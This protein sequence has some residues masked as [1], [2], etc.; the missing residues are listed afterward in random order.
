MI[1][2]AHHH[3]WR[4][5]PGQTPWLD[6][7]N[8]LGPLR[9][10]YLGGELAEHLRANGIARSVIVQSVDATRDT[11]FMRAAAREHDFIAGIVA[12]VP[13]EDPAATAKQLGRYAR[14]PAIKGFRHLILFEP[15]PDWS[16]RPNVLTSLR[17]V[18]DAGYTWDASVAT[19]RHLEH[20]ATIAE[21][22]PHLAQVID[23][24]GK[25]PA[26]ESVWEPWASLMAR[27]ATYP[28]VC[29]KLSGLLNVAT[30]AN[31][32]PH[33]L[34]PYVDHVLHCFGARRTMIAS[35]WPVSELGAGYTATW[36][37]TLGMLAGL[38]AHDREQVLGASAARFYRLS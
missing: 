13:L 34:Q 12:W 21:R 22:I 25:P 3:L 30:L 27:A 10:D 19:P 17:L 4:Y 11:E 28:N 16:I 15:D 8:E 6:A 9:R 1:V 29:V 20:V 38:E 31:P 23:H 37:A 14:E 33:Q 7:R 26:A 36:Q 35:N 18:A 2:D 24:L 32:L 5:R